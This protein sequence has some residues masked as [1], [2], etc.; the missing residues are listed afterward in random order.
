[1]PQKAKEQTDKAKEYI[2]FHCGKSYT[3]QKGNFPKVRS[4][5][6]TNNDGYLPWCKTCVV[7]QFEK[8]EKKYGSDEAL[9]RTCMKYDLYFSPLVIR[10]IQS[11]NSNV[12][13]SKI[14]AYISK[15]NLA[16][17]SGS[18]YDDTS[19][20]DE[21]IIAQEA[22]AEGDDVAKDGKKVAKKSIKIFGSGFDS[23]AYPYMQS[24]YDTLISSC[25]E[26]PD[27]A[28]QTY[29]KQLSIIDYQITKSAQGDAKSVPQLANS[30]NTL[31]EKGGFNKMS[32]SSEGTGLGSWL[33]DIEQ[34]TPAEYYKDKK[35]YE[36]EDK[37]GEYINRFIVR[38]F[39]NL[40][41]AGKPVMDDEF[42]I[43][44]AEASGGDDI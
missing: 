26:H 2:C 7:E 8:Y 5:L 37:L 22:E 13:N 1:M 39:A 6:Y 4:Q 14:L 17:I 11:A 44:D 12:T 10:M 33:R 21:Q 35:I 38:P 16:Q 32:G 25:G 42:S 34:F 28:Q 23:E 3:I 43:T 41:R 31:L 19:V 15:S 36:D 40:F 9:R 24:H 18:C 20:E 29:A 30:Y 27:I